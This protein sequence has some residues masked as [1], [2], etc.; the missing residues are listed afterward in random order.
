MHV[1]NTKSVPA[2]QLQVASWKAM[3]MFA[4]FAGFIGGVQLVAGHFAGQE[5]MSLMLVLI[6]AVSI[7]P[8][9]IAGAV[10]ARLAK[11]SGLNMVEPRN[12]LVVG[13]KAGTI[14]SAVAWGTLLVILGPS[15]LSKMPDSMLAA[16]LAMVVFVA[17]AF[18]G[19]LQ[20]A[21]TGLLIGRL[22]LE[23]VQNPAT[24]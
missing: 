7:L 1:S 2:P 19:A 13:A 4:V 16:T 5:K 14:T 18:V 22:T 20:G 3:P 9:G 10:Y 6:Y 15:Q 11:R 23:Q 12:R 17:A 8:W 24:A 21:V